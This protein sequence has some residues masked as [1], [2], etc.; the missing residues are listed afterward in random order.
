M[1]EKP[2]KPRRKPARW[3]SAR[4]PGSVLLVLAGGKGTGKSTLLN[5]ALD[6]RLPLF[7]AGSDAVFQAFSVPGTASE[8]ALSPQEVLKRNTWA[9]GPHLPYLA[10]L[11]APPQTLLVHLDLM[12]FCRLKRRE[13]ESLASAD[14]NLLHM[15]RSRQARIFGRYDTIVVNTLYAPWRT[16][17]E[18]FQDRSSRVGREA[19]PNELLLYDLDAPASEA[20]YEAIYAAWSRF[21]TTISLKRH[22]VTRWYEK[23]RDYKIYDTYAAGRPRTATRSPAGGSGPF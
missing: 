6:T 10:A 3:T 4:V 22:F 16:A 15:T 19:A 14:A 8:F 18:R 17:A 21:L 23:S 9:S 11:A 7:G 13:W 12:N 2:D 5:H 1:P 20:T